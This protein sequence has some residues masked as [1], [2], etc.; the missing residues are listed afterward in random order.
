MVKNKLLGKAGVGIGRAAEAAKIGGA[1]VALERATDVL[2][3]KLIN[4]IEGG[5]IG[6]AATGGNPLGAVGGGLMGFIL[7]DGERIMPVDMVAIPAYQYGM[8]L[9]GKEP[10]FQI[11]IKEGELVT[12][13]MP[14]DM[15]ISEAIIEAPINTPTKRKRAKGAG[16]PKKYAKMGFKK[17]WREY[18]KTPAYKKKKASKKRRK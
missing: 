16:L 5:L 4:T 9:Q 8:V 3:S 11:Y 13:I 14:T 15:M 2:D 12:P 7:A 1:A 10:T 17:G 18:K 6:W